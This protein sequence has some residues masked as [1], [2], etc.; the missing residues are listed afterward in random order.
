[1]NCFY[2]QDRP[3]IGICKNC[4]R[5]LCSD[6]AVEVP[7][8]L[9]CKERCERQVLLL[10]RLVKGSEQAGRKT[11]TAYIATG[12]CIGVLAGT[13]TAIASTVF[14]HVPSAVYLCIPF[15][16]LAA[17]SIGIGIRYRMSDQDLKT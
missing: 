12:L 5:G 10:G 8:G 15:W 9:A 6:C 2:H 3:A 13:L 11:G 7:D 4:Q 16:P 1:M 17:V 14:Q